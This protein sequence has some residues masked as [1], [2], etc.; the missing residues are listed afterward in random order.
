MAGV[1]FCLGHFFEQPLP[2]I[3]VLMRY[4]LHDWNPD[5]KRALMRKA[6]LFTAYPGTTLLFP[7]QDWG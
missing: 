2:K 7:D 3:V 4:I 5:E 6:I 1:Q